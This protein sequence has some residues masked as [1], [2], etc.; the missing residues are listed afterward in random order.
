MLIDLLLELKKGISID[1]E[2]LVRESLD[3]E[4]HVDF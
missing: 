4:L 3:K 1:A 2:S